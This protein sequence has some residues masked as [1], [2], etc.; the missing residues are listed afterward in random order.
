MW[1]IEYYQ[2]PNNTYPV[3]DFIESLEIK[4]RARTARTLDLLEEFG[5]ELGMP[6]ARHLHDKLWE[7]RVR[8]KKDRHRIIYA[9]LKDRTFVLL[10]GFTKKSS[11]VPRQDMD[12][13]QKRMH[14]Y[15]ARSG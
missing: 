12:I 15:I 3:K 13:A 4:A 7:I 1:D 9:L 6:Y 11:S 10:H 5:I 8:F 2:A 14:D